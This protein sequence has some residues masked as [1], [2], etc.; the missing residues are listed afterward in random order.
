MFSGGGPDRE[1]G[2]GEGE[3]TA[4]ASLRGA[5]AARGPALRTDPSWAAPSP[6]GNHS[7]VGR[8]SG[9]DRLPLASGPSRTP[10]GVG[11]RSRAAAPVE[12]WRMKVVDKSWENFSNI[13]MFGV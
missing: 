3:L 12:A 6:G 13:W 9:Q 5:A 4:L 7:E 2:A 8:G 11:H 1:G 10:V